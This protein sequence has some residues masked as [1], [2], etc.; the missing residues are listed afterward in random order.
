[1]KPLVR[2]AAAAFFCFIFPLYAEELRVQPQGV[3]RVS[4]ERAESLPLSYH[5]AV[6][7]SLGEDRR[8]FRGVEIEVAAPG[9]W[10]SHRG[11]LAVSAYAN[12]ELLSGPAAGPGGIAESF[13]PGQILDLRGTMFFREPLPGKIQTVYQIPLRPAHGMKTNPYTQVLSVHV[14]PSSFP[15]LFRLAPAVKG[16][17]E[18]LERMAFRLSAKPILMDE[19]AVRLRFYYPPQLPQRPFI[20]LIDDLVVE[21]PPE[22]MILKEGEHHLTVLS[23]DYR[24]E[25]RVFLVERAKVLDLHIELQD[26]SPLLIFEGPEGAAVFLDNEPVEGSV[27]VEPGIH[28]IRFQVSDYTI[29]RTVRV[30]KG[31][32]Y[33][34]VLTVDVDVSESE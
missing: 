21:Q 15:I 10:L 3:L 25:N 8:F 27:L 22:E 16:I 17:G 1:M 6:L 11:S 28:E 24:N 30:E 23:D 2:A 14:P 12:L 33:R 19:G 9:G 7:I 29:L 13:L 34:I 5:G 32:T 20:L 4:G 18:E 26:P 31:K